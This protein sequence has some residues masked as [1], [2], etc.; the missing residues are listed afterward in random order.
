MNILLLFLIIG[1]TDFKI[2]SQHFII[3]SKTDLKRLSESVMNTAEKQYESIKKMMPV[4][5]DSKI[6]VKIA[7]SMSEYESMQPDGA[8][9]PT[10]SVGIA[11]PKRRLV[12]LRGDFSHGPNEMLKTFR[13]ELAH[14]FLHNYSDRQI[15]IW[16]SE[17]F[18]MYFEDRGGL[19]RNFSLIRQAFS[20]EY[21]DI[22][23]LTDGFPN[24]PVDIHNAYL[25]A[26]EF[27]SYLLSQ[28]KEEGL[29]RVFE[30]LGKGDDIKYAIYKVS[31]K[32]LSEIERDFKRSARFKYAFLPVITS[33]T[34]LWIFL[35]I[36]FIYVFIVKKRRAD[37]KLE[38]MRAEEEMLL[39]KKFESEAFTEEKKKY[40][41]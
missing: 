17:G 5:L 41:N 21:I 8:K 31:G 13:H 26:S 36:L 20:N 37:T 38:V 24:N 15:P 7:A 32:T 12:V 40:L 2:E 1:A 29:Y 6:T 14:I 27:F 19:G 18:S 16:F 34:T 35:T 23:K 11:Y 10:W 28:I 22:E 9:A 39:N 4:S 30:Y 3:E 33:S 25:T